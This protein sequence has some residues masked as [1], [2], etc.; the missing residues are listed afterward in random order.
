M[1]IL[2]VRGVLR[3]S[4]H[5]KVCIEDGYCVAAF[6]KKLQIMTC[7]SML[8]SSD[9][10]SRKDMLVKIEEEALQAEEVTHTHTHTHIPRSMEDWFHK[11]HIYHTSGVEHVPI[12][13]LQVCIIIFPPLHIQA[14]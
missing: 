7:E 1:C 11:E 2:C 3:A 9:I 13:K 10:T 12:R 8:L 4:C 14:L 6:Q 5:T